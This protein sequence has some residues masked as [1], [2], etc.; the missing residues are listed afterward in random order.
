MPGTTA[1][2]WPYILPADHPLEYPA[3][4][5]ALAN[6]L[7]SRGLAGELTTWTPRAPWVASGQLLV[8][9]IGPLVLVDGTVVPTTQQALTAGANV[10]IGDVPPDLR[11]QQSTNGFGAI[12]D[13]GSYP[14]FV[15]GTITNTGD[16][17]VRLGSQAVTVQ[18]AGYIAVNVVYRIATV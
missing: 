1:D 10:I 8:T 14:A 7:D 2:G 6:L 5:Q 18:T 9:R 16:V 17:R 15:R 4:S 3:Q 11:P 13:N 12:A